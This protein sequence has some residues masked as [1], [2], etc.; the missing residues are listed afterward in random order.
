MN[1]ALH[2]CLLLL[3]ILAPLPLGSNREWAWTLVSFAV[4][5][6]ALAW[7]LQALARPRTVFTGPG[8]AVVTGFAAVCAW[9]WLQTVAWVPPEWKHPLWTMLPWLAEHGGGSISLSAEGSFVALMRLISYG[10]VFF[11]AMQFGRDRELA[12]RTFRWLA[13]A[14]FAYALYGLAAYW[15]ELSSVLWVQDERFSDDV[16]STFVNRNSYA[17]YAGLCLLCA[18]AVF[19]R[20]F[21]NRGGAAFAMPMGRAQKIESFIL[22]SWKPLT[23]ILLMTAALILTH[24][25]GG[26]FGA[27]SGVLLLLHLLSR[28]QAGRSRLSRAVLGSAV[29]AAVIA[30]VLTSEVLLQRIDR[31]DIDNNAR[32]EVYGMA[33][34]AV[35]DNPLLG[36]GYGTFSDSFRL[37][38]DDRLAAHYDKAHNTYLENIFELGWPMALILFA[39]IAWLGLRC[40]RGAGERGRDWEYPA[41]GAA[42]TVLVGVHSL[43]DFSLQ[44]PA[45]AIT[46]ACVLGVGYAQSFSSVDRRRGGVNQP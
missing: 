19:N 41:A 33:V 37:Y 45:V 30:F 25:R 31:I 9:A 27:L 10:V 28:R 16:R 5:V 6:I 35:A 24:S 3:V 22:K 38:R 32:L 2:G 40:L 44:M 39:C 29:L 1:A 7:I 36:F 4:G 46:Y 8:A 23:G 17:T 34:D 15:G 12:A 11:L 13:F 43:F 26:F 20:R 21:A 14:G 18:I 42:A